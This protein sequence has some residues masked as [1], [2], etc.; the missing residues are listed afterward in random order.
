MRA[1]GYDAFARALA[2]LEVAAPWQLASLSEAQFTERFTIVRNS[3]QAGR[4]DAL[5]QVFPAIERLV[6][7]DYFTALAALFSR[8]HPPRSA[9]LH[10]YGEG[11]AEF[12]EHFPPL[13]DWPFLG[14]VA[15]LEWARLRAFHAADMPPLQLAGLTEEELLHLL[16]ISLQLHPSVT[17][18]RSVYPLFTLWR[19]GEP[20][21]SNWKGENVLVW[22][23]GL[24]LMT[25]SVSD[26]SADLLEQ[27]Q[28]QVRFSEAA[29]VLQPRLE[30]AP[31]CTQFSLFLHWQVL[32]R[33][34]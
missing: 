26:E 32:S 15:R 28:R 30:L 27:L 2:D 4:I 17:L 20:P 3:V 12:I 18:L 8:E 10:E 31:L 19:G 11:L 14:D 22:R 23:Q 6:G 1:Q 7:A 16:D 5:R 34:A 25:R 9:V 29:R 33:L 21:Y 13:A 24:Q